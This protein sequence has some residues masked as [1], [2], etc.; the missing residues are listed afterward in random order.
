MP[1]GVSGTLK[2]LKPVTR[3]TILLLP[4]YKCLDPTDTENNEDMF[5]LLQ[6]PQQQQDAT[7]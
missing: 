6:P 2:S 1:G 7:P 3:P 4:L 5:S